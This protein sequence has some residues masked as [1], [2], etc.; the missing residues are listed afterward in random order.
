MKD[1][2][3]A[4]SKL[5]E[6][7]F[8]D[9]VTDEEKSLVET[10]LLDCQVCRDVL[11]SMEELRTLIRVPV[12]EAVE[13]EDFPWVWQKIEKEI[14]SQ[15]KPSWWQVLRSRVDLR[16][17]LQR[18]V[19]IPVMATIAILLFITTQLIIKKTPSFSYPS[20]VEYV[21]SNTYNV[22]VFESEK[23]KATV[24]WLFEAPEQNS[25]TS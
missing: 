22:M 23:T 25:S 19:L 7:Y 15:E 10:H 20:V 11:S 9:E 18:R 13:Q 17:L 5:L 16:F 6:K 14:R 1:S 3:S 12:E 2:C 8:D 4:L 21:E 24:I